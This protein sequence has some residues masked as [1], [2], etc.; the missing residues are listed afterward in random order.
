MHL[1]NRLILVTRPQPGATETARQIERWHGQALLAPLTAIEPVE[2]PAPLRDALSR[3]HTYDALLVTSANGARAL[4]AA[5]P[6]GIIPPPLFA[7]GQKSANVLRERGWMVNVPDQAEGG[8]KLGET[9]LERLPDARRLLFLRAE[10]GREELINLLTAQGRTVDTVA[11]YRSVAAERL[12]DAVLE[13]LPEVAAMLLFSPRGAGILLDLLPDGP[14]PGCVLAALSPLTA[15]VLTRRGVG[16]AVVPPLP[17]G[18]ALLR[19]LNDY[20]SRSPN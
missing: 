17:S 2:D 13:R 7:V 15:E 1:A 16:V 5:L 6:D 14:P 4:S 19:A 11:V 20:W 18:E 12:P 9:L 10:E 3:L 8:E